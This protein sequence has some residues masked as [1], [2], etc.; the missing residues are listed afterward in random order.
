MSI[1][2]D[3]YKICIVGMITAVLSVL[4]KKDKPEMAICTTIAGGA[5]ILFGCRKWIVGII[6]ALESVIAKSG[7]SSEYF[8]VTLKVICVA[9]I[10]QYASE[11]CRDCG[12]NAIGLKIELAGKLI[13]LMLTLP[14]I[15][16]FLNLCINTIGS[17]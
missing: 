3:I 16:V 2:A 14:L 17:L 8:G 11:L 9:Y 10:C 5:V 6:N 15:E 4:I 7:V 1:Q 13:I 12:E